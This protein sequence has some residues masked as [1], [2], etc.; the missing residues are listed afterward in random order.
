MA[1][2]YGSKNASALRYNPFNASALRYGSHA[3][4]FGDYDEN[5][6][7]AEY[8][9][10][11]PLEDNTYSVRVKD[12]A[13][14]PDTVVIP[15]RYK[16]KAVTQIGDYAFILP[17]GEGTFCTSITTLGIPKSITSIGKMAFFLCT[18]LETVEFEEG[19]QLV[20]IGE[21]AFSRCAKLQGINI[22]ASVTSI[23]DSAFL[24]CNVITEITFGENSQL[25]S[26]GEYAFSNCWDITHIVIPSGVTSISNY[27]FESCKRLERI[28]LHDS[29]TS[30]GKYAFKSCE[31]LISI[32]IPR[33]VTSIGE[34]AFR[35][36]S[37][38]TNITIPDSVTSIGEQAFAGCTALTINCE[39]TE[40][41]SGWHEDWNSSNRPVYW[42]YMGRYLT[43]TLLDDDTYSVVP[44]DKSNIPS[45]FVIPASYNGKAVTR[46]GASAFNGSSITGITI[47]SDVTMIMDD[48]FYGCTKLETVT[49]EGTSITDIRY[50]AFYGCTA[51][52]NIVIPDGVTHIRDY[53][54]ANC[55]GLVSITIPA[56]VTHIGEYAFKNCTATINCKATEQP[57]GWNSNWNYSGCPVTWGYTG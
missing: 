55:T 28:T 34:Y 54:F 32:I 10:F 5:A 8:F 11:T 52:K 37:G 24:G 30:I 35:G 29:V 53:A 19:S 13:N 9:I 17:V 49:F 40:Q 26:I 33:A 36:C 39:A 31:R 7:P 25:V 47:P 56:S 22:P 27:A 2:R 41:P 44:T 46:I 48:A 50:S 43:G 15:R 42:N 21:E 45:D 14:V 20:T 4:N 6:T 38:L 1:L 12:V 51:I 57:S 16:G 3:L 23:G 18:N